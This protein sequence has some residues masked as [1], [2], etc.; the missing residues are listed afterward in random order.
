MGDP[1]DIELK[2]SAWCCKDDKRVHS[3]EATSHDDRCLTETP[4]HLG[5]NSEIIETAQEC[6]TEDID[7]ALVDDVEVVDVS[8]FPLVFW[9]SEAKSDQ[10][11]DHGEQDGPLG[12]NR[13]VIQEYEDNGIDDTSDEVQDRLNDRNITFVVK[14]QAIKEGSICLWDWNTIGDYYSNSSFMT[15]PIFLLLSLSQRII[16]FF[17]DAVFSLLGVEV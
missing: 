16:C 15:S 14:L 7:E 8:V 5:L 4:A 3:D 11:A 17:R 9:A 2:H 13:S 12:S 1:F 6:K 10:A